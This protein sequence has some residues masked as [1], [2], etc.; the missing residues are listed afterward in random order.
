MLKRGSTGRRLGLLV[1]VAA[2]ATMISAGI[3][4]AMGS[5]IVGQTD[6]TFDANT[7]TIDQGQVAQLQVTGSDHNATANQNGPDGRALFRSPTISG[8]AAGVD[9]TQYL[10]AGHYTFFCTIHPSTMQ[11]SLTVTGNGTPQARRSAKLSGKKTSVA[12]AI[13]KGV[14]V[15]INASTK[16]DGAT[17]TLKLGKSALGKATLS[18]A[19]GPQTD[20]IKLNKAGKSKLRGRSKAKLT[21]VADIPFGFPASGKIKLG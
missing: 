7:Y 5:T 3:A 20:R 13:K 18:L 1:A 4:L 8:G 9:G 17:L 11:A 2:I 14:L 16:I 6:N 15:N 10:S 12:K 19:A 21:V